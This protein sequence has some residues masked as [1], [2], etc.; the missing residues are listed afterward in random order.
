MKLTYSERGSAHLVIIIILAVAV[1]GL[2]G[3]VFWQNFMNTN[4]TN[5]SQTAQDATTESD[6][7]AAQLTTI[8][9]EEWGVEGDY[10]Q[11]PDYPMTYVYDAESTFM[12]VYLDTPA[13]PSDCASYGGG[14]NR[15]GADQTVRLDSLTAAERYQENG[16]DTERF[17]KIGEYYFEYVGPQ[18]V[19]KMDETDPDQ[20]AMVSAAQATRELFDSLKLSN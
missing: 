3:F 16:G 10:A 9:I 6:E 20:I 8:A 2:L 4:D 18:S 1:L 12:T 14:I 13:L 19:C 17:V 15:Y 5:Q 11:E 7:P